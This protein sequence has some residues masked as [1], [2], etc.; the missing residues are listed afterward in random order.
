MK[1]FCAQWPLAQ[2][3]LYFLSKLENTHTHSEHHGAKENEEANK[4][5]MG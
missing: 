3:A 1:S 4:E 2:N 5:M